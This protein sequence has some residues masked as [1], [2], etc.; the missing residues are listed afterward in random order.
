MYAYIYFGKVRYHV[1]PNEEYFR[2]RHSNCKRVSLKLGAGSLFFVRRVFRMTKTWI[3]AKICRPVEF[4]RFL[5]KTEIRNK[6]LCRW[7]NIR[8]NGG[9]KKN[10]SLYRRYLWTH[11]CTC[12]HDSKNN[13]IAPQMSPA[14]ALARTTTTSGQWKNAR[15][16][17][18]E[19][20]H[21]CALFLCLCLNN[22]AL[23]CNFN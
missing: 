8:G 19:K 18:Y 6:D 23:H 13:I 1:S 4:K 7:C 15:C 16:P 12:T 3:P 17:T 10:I 21:G 20:N 22:I 2:N 5:C 14:R 11:V 9:K